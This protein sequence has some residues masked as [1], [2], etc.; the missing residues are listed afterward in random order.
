MQAPGEGA[1]ARPVGRF[2]EKP[3]EATARGYLDAGDYFWNSGMFVLGPPAAISMSWIGA[4]RRRWRKSLCRERTAAASV[5]LDFFRPERCLSRAAP[6]DSIDYAVMEKTEQSHGWFQRSFD[7][8]DVG[9]MVRHSGRHPPQDELPVTTC[10][11]DVVTVGTEGSATCSRNQ[12]LVGTIGV[13][14]TSMVVETADAV[15][16]ADKD[17]VQDVKHAGRQSLKALASATST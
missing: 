15:L 6:A 7:W 12:R 14:K 4:R 3:D 8:S 2:V 13:R 1:A 5:D 11:G 17:Q 16:I 9:S 10:S